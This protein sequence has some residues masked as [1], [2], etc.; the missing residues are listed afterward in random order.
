[1]IP[2]EIMIIITIVMKLLADEYI[3][4]VDGISIT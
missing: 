3:L 4:F 1:M 2:T